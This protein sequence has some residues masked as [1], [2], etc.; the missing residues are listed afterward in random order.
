MVG[1]TSPF[2]APTLPSAVSAWSRRACGR[3]VYAYAYVYVYVYA[4]KSRARARARLRGGCVLHGACVRQRRLLTFV[5][6]HVALDRTQVTR[7]LTLDTSEPGLAV[8]DG[9]AL[10]SLARLR[11]GCAAQAKGKAHDE[12]GDGSHRAQAIQDRAGLERWRTLT[13]RADPPA[14]GLTH[15]VEILTCNWRK[16]ARKCL[17]AVALAEP[18]IADVA[19]TPAL[20]KKLKH[21]SLLHLLC[22][23]TRVQRR[24]TL[25][26]PDGGLGGKSV[27]PAQAHCR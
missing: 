25:V 22:R 9:V 5:L 14:C 24:G 3:A 23:L 7:T 26:G 17:H 8:G 6:R 16:K 11:R 15:I 13:H 4:E 12:C 20:S 21:F 27:V 18:P 2:F 10:P 1:A 19:R